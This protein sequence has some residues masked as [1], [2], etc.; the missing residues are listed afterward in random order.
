MAYYSYRTV[1]RNFN[2]KIGYACH[3][4]SELQKES[5]RVDIVLVILNARSAATFHATD[6]KIV[7]TQSMIRDERDIALR[8]H[9]S[10]LATS[11]FPSPML[12]IVE[13]HRTR[14]EYGP[15]ATL[16]TI[17]LYIPSKIWHKRAYWQ[18]LFLQIIVHFLFS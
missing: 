2:C 6:E 13:F 16:H 15:I 3:R 8:I 11:S 12:Y 4:N 10:L 17:Q 14:S 7:I 9:I 1:I 18:L 5:I